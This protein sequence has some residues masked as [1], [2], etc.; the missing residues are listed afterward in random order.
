MS[1]Q[2]MSEVWE[3]ST[4]TGAELLVL[5]GLADRA[6]A[7]DAVCWPGIRDIARRARVSERQAQ[8]HITALIS[9]GELRRLKMGGGDPSQTSVYQVAVGRYTG[10]ISDTG[11]VSSATGVPVTSVTGVPVTSKA[12]TGD[13]HVTRPVTPMSPK[14][15]YN[16]Q[17]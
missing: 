8:R 14:P 10:V 4:A 7:E 2:V 9:R 11:R 6:R 1:I 3:H 15:S 13:T 12:K 16:R 17:R 5:L